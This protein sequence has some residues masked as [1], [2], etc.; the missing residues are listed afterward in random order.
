MPSWRQMRQQQAAHWMGLHRRFISKNIDSIS[1]SFLH[2]ASLVGWIKSEKYL[3]KYWISL[4]D[5]LTSMTCDHQQIVYYMSVQC[6][7]ISLLNVELVKHFL[8]AFISLDLSNFVKIRKTLLSQGD[9][10]HLK[11]ENCSFISQ[12]VLR[13]FHSQMKWDE[14][15]FKDHFVCDQSAYMKIRKFIIN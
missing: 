1:S 7:K 14:M 4:G 8:L 10:H 3:N 15:R 13:P 5:S 12:E 9:F 6:I 2:R 11:E